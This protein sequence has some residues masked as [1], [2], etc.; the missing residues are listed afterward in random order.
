MRGLFSRSEDFKGGGPD[1]TFEIS[2][3]I[4][5]L[6]LRMCQDFF[7]KPHLLYILRRTTETEILYQA[8]SLSCASIKKASMF[9][10]CFLKKCVFIEYTK[11]K[12]QKAKEGNASVIFDKLHYF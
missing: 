1:T 4:Y 9:T 12:V 3:V 11:T 6:V 2:R 8:C 7:S 10:R 5:V